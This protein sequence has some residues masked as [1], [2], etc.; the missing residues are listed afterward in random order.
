[1]NVKVVWEKKEGKSMG[2]EVDLVRGGDRGG[3]R[4]VERRECNGD[5][6]DSKRDMEV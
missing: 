2:G 1:M 6:R 4:E 3:F 5:K